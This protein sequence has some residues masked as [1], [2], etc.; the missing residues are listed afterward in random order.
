MASVPSVPGSGVTVAGRVAVDKIM[1]AHY[2]DAVKDSKID[3]SPVWRDAK[4]SIRHLNTISPMLVSVIKRQGA[5]APFEKRMEALE[6]MVSSVDSL[7]KV[8]AEGLAD[9]PDGKKYDRIELTSMLGH[10]VSRIGE[11]APDDQEQH[12][13]DEMLR[14]VVGV[15]GDEKFKERHSGT[16]HLMMEKIGYLRVDSAETMSTRLR[17]AMH[18][19]SLRLYESIVDE[20]LSNGRGVYFTYGLTRTELLSSI[21][22]DFNGM[23]EDFVG[24]ADF[25]PVLSNDQRAIIMQSWIKQASEIYRAE[26]VVNTLLMMD[27]FKAGETISKD[28]FR[29]RFARAKASLPGVLE[30]TREAAGKSLSDLARFVGFDGIPAAVEQQERNP[31]TPQL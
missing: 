30:R 12:Q 4:L 3:Y 13:I 22:A 8:M 6:F 16:A 14:T 11:S 17:V 29:E 18:Q 7:A 5:F 2:R 28:E 27:W 25:A 15:Y 24:A 23:I 1:D 26:Y 19:A 31:D 21:G 10:V 9:T 20:R